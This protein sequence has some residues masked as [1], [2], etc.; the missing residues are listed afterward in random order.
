M[1]DS[2]SLRRDGLFGWLGRA[3]ER[4]R[5]S[6]A[7]LRHRLAR[8]GGMR[9]LLL[10]ASMPG[11]S[12]VNAAVGLLLPAL[13]GPA[14]FG[15][16][17]IAVTLFQYGLILDLGMSQLLDRRLPLLMDDG[18]T[19]QR[20]AFVHDVLWIRLYTAAT[21]L[22][23]GAAGLAG[24][25]MLGSLPFPIE[26]G[27]LSLAAGLAFMLALGPMCVWRATS[28][29]VPFARWNV[30]CALILAVGRPA[31]MIAGGLLGCFGALAVG[32]AA[33]AT[34]LNWSMPL[35]HA[36]LPGPRLTARLL[37]EGAP[38]FA[39]SFVWAFYMTANRWV[40]S[41]LAQQVELGQFAFGSNVVYLIVGT[42]GALAQLH[43]PAI[44][45]RAAAG[46]RHAVSAQLCRDLS[47]LAVLMTVPSAVG[48]AAGPRLIDIFYPTFAGA[49][50]SVQRLL[51]A[52]PALVVASWL[53]PLSLSTAARPWIE[54]VLIYPA[55]LVVLVAATWLGFAG[56]GI[57][58]AAW[59]L[60]ASAM[61]L[62]AM[63]LVNLR[64]I[65]LL[66]T[67]DALR[68]ALA[69]G[70]GTASLAALAVLA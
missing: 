61:P 3:A 17:A 52:V 63:Q 53:M 25:A 16:Y 4:A 33:L 18:A 69:V 54:G 50:L 59:G 10:Y 1:S 24:A 51:V 15:Q 30:A 27:I 31:G 26:A 14:Q 46:A 68:I 49:E 35:R 56:G 62:V 36:K 13:L 8:P 43:Y 9:A 34:R 44:V 23:L 45:T 41:I 28:Q 48:I 21:A 20:Q 29:R 22:A 2:G 32:Y 6:R 47:L 57:A 19:P 5:S 11:L 38:L 39:T 37:A 60:A 7:A 66:D 40:V 58:G 65:G 67:A 70:A 12:A 42:V 55:A 64:Q